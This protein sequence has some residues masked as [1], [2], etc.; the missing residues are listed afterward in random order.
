MS[1]H[2]LER[3]RKSFD[4]LVEAGVYDADFDHAPAAK[5]FVAG[6]L[7]EIAPSLPR[8]TPLSVLDCGCGTGAW[9]GFLHAQLTDG[10]FEGPALYGFDLSERM[11]ALAQRKLQ[12]LAPPHHLRPGNLTDR[13]SYVFEDMTRHFDLIFTYD[14]VQQLPPSHQSDAC[15][16]IADALAPGGT[17]LIFDNDAASRFGRRMALRKILTRYAGL[18]LVPRYYCNAKYPPL[19]KI[20]RTLE[21]A[22]GLRA[23]IAVRSDGIKRA[24]VVERQGSQV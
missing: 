6:V 13:R 19:E 11:V 7:Q 24:L 20:C 22:A 15:K 3:Q 16:A 5:L 14:V 9:L 1:A 10:G 17:A 23:R 12:G 4:G 2:L 18:R 8:R 21:R